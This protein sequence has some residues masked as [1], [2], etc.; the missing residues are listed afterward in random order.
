MYADFDIMYR[1]I[2]SGGSVC[3][4][5]NTCIAGC[6]QKNDGDRRSLAHFASVCGEHS[7]KTAEI[8]LPHIAN[9]RM[10]GCQSGERSH[11][12][13]RKIS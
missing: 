9:M 1:R 5:G 13:L 6:L 8:D 12:M 3:T 11:L 4:P 7:K 10:N 2:F